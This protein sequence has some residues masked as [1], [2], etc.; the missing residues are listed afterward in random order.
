MH[1]GCVVKMVSYGYQDC[2]FYYGSWPPSTLKANGSEIIYALTRA[3]YLA[4]LNP[5][6]CTVTNIGS[7]DT[8][9]FEGDYPDYSVNNTAAMVDFVNNTPNGTIIV[10][11]MYDDVTSPA[12]QSEY[13]FLLDKLGVDLSALE[14]RGKFAFVA[15]VGYPEKAIVRMLP[16]GGAPANLTVTV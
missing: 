5:L 14:F 15:Q 11:I 9:Q 4:A 1:T 16:A 13:P 6:R 7:F 12:L 8:S 3:I 10:S 2:G